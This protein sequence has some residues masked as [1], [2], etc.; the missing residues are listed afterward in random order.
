M[1]PHI[2]CKDGTNFESFFCTIL[3]K[4]KTL[5]QPESPVPRA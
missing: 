4:I 5:K 3:W 2:A 1:G